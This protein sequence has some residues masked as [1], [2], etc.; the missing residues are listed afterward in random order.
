MDSYGQDLDFDPGVLN[1]IDEVLEVLS[2]DLDAHITRPSAQ[3]LMVAC[4]GQWATYQLHCYWQSDLWALHV[5]ALMDLQ[6]AKDRRPEVTRLLA[7]I[8]ARLWIGHFELNPDEWVPIYRHSL[9][10]RGQKQVAREQL[11]DL[12]DAAI[13]ECDRFFPTFKLVVAR[14]FST[15]QAIEA[16]I[17]ETHGEA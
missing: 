11:E 2:S 10:L 8:N 3:E 12:I 9:L 7:D 6:I 4:R 13:G 1:P 16:S 5:A 14:N 17:L 15:E